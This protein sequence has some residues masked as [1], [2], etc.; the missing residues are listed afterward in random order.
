MYTKRCV[1]ILLFIIMIL[2]VAGSSSA[3]TK[4]ILGDANGDG[5]VNSADAS[6]I[7]RASVGLAA[8]DGLQE[9]ADVD[10]NDSL[11][12][13]DAAAILRYCVGA[14]D[15][16]VNGNLMFRGDV[17]KDSYPYDGEIFDLNTVTFTNAACSVSVQPVNS[18]LPLSFTNAGKYGAY[19]IALEHPKYII[20]GKV[21]YTAEIRKATYD[22]SGVTFKSEVQYRNSESFED[23]V[24][25]HTITVKG[26]LPEGV[27]VAYY[28]D[29]E[30]FT[31]A[32]FVGKY[33]IT[34]VFTGDD[35]NYEKI[36][37]MTATLEIRSSWTGWL[38]LD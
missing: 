34:A 22:M 36:P 21:N 3:E 5:V 30:P 25:F 28:C 4:I 12:A 29:G 14:Q 24:E 20:G 15:F 33:V 26:E 2:G 9:K 16:V 37:D 32:S 13:A 6:A 19:E 31:S 35:V 17:L 1:C 18:D 27:T 11:N 38:K 23:T 10:L 8:A 7:L